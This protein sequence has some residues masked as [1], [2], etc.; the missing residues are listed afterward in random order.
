[1]KRL[2]L[3]FSVLLILI[4]YTFF[5]EKYVLT[6]CNNIDNLLHDCASLITD[7]KYS[8]AESSVSKLYDTWEKSDE[9]LSIIVGD[10]TVREPQKTIVSIKLSFEDKNYEEC[11]ITIRECQ[12][13]IHE[14]AES[15]RTNLY[16]LL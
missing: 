1:M 16:N 5:S 13:Y 9:F 2:A 7:E 14:I 4:L 10:D 11:L 15:N 3:A 6:F 12:G 8:Q